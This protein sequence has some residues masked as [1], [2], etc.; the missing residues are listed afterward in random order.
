ML[1][2]ACHSTIYIMLKTIFLLLEGECVGPTVGAADFT[3][4][5]LYRSIIVCWFCCGRWQYYLQN[6]SRAGSPLTK[7][8]LVYGVRGYLVIL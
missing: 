2:F 1:L 4:A 5:L 7:V 8:T 6:V 3:L